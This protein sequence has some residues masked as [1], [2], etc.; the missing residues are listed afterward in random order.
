MNLRRI[1]TTAK[2]LGVGNRSALYLVIGTQKW[3]SLHQQLFRP[4]GTF[5]PS[6]QQHGGPIICASD[7]ILNPQ[8]QSC[9]IHER[10]S[11]HI[12]ESPEARISI[13]IERINSYETAEETFHSYQTCSREYRI[14][15][16][17]TFYQ[18]YESIETVSVGCPSKRAQVVDL[19]PRIRRLAET[20]FHEWPHKAI[21]SSTAASMS[22]DPYRGGIYVL[23]RGFIHMDHPKL[24]L[25]HGHA[26]ASES[27][28]FPPGSVIKKPQL[29]HRD[30]SRASEI[31]YLSTQGLSSRR[32][33]AESL[34][35]LSTIRQFVYN[36]Q[37]TRF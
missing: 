28:A 22:R 36:D 10:E 31:V 24:Q 34:E 30:H 2:I 3:Q 25:R 11:D 26:M 18:T 9:E 12:G 6:H 21:A 8:G 32:Y 27:A 17:S 14:Q 29:N 19:L 15:C 7:S 5:Q 35:S 33:N 4:S 23:C 1:H 37:D 13:E 20:Y 16:R